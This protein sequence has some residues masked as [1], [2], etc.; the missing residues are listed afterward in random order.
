MKPADGCQMSYSK[1]LANHMYCISLP[2]TGAGFEAGDASVHL[3]VEMPAG[4]YTR[5]GQSV[6]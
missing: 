6:V 4:M 5:Q 3:Q 2:A 1:M